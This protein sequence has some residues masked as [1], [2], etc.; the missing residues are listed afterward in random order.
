M[1][2][3]EVNCKIYFWYQKNSKRAPQYHSSRTSGILE[4]LLVNWNEN[5]LTDTAKDD[6]NTHCNQTR[7]LDQF[8][9]RTVTERKEQLEMSHEVIFRFWVNQV[10]WVYCLANRFSI[11]DKS[12][13]EDVDKYTNCLN[14]PFD[15]NTFDSLHPIPIS[16][17]IIKTAFQAVCA[18]HCSLCSL[19][20]H[21]HQ[22][23]LC[24][25]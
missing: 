14:V 3:R 5:T 21:S 19:K 10:T 2:M 13:L 24:Y 9:L 15:S 12:V 18:T 17:K 25:S 20:W 6:L 11:W 7:I 4:T 22:G 23:C 16:I 8:N 1:L